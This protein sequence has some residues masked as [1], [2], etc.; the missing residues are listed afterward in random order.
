MTDFSIVEQRFHEI[1]KRRLTSEIESRLPL[2]PWESEIKEYPTEIKDKVFSSKTPLWFPDLALP[3]KF[4]VKF[5]DQL[6]EACVQIIDSFEPQ[7][8]QM[9]KVV[10]QLFADQLSLDQLN[11]LQDQAGIINLAGV[12]RSAT[13]LEKNREDYG[14]YEDCTWQQQMTVSLLAAQQILSALTL[15]LSSLQSSL[16]KEWTTPKGKITVKADY[17]AENKQLN[18]IINTSFEG[19][20]SWQNRGEN[21]TVSCNNSEATVIHF[22]DVEPET[23]YPINIRLAENNL[24]FVLKVENE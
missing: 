23:V 22:Y 15:P 21:V 16:T 24:T 19:E 1:L 3:I 20:I 14:N 2:Y 12:T 9:V 4:P 17:V 10:S 8:L 13:V 5:I 18:V 7:P 11:F 6:L